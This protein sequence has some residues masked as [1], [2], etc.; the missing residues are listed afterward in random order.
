M[1]YLLNALGDERL[2]EL[3]QE[4]LSDEWTPSVPEVATDFGAYTMR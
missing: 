2:E 4:G 1:H 3:R